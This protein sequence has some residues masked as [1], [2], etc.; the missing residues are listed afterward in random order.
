MYCSLSSTWLFFLLIFYIYTYTALCVDVDARYSC[1]QILALYRA[2]VSRQKG[3]RVS[4]GGRHASIWLFP[5][6]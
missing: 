4:S 1:F 6:G 5:S 3:K 2:P